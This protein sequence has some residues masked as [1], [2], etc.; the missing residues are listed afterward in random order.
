M[1]Y[2]LQSVCL[3]LFFLTPAAVLIVRFLKPSRMPWWAVV[4][5]IALGGWIFVN[6]YVYFRFEHL[7][8]LVAQHGD[9][10]PED[11]VEDLYA[12]GAQRVMTFLLGGLYSLIYSIPFLVL[13]GVATFI[14]NWLRPPQNGTAAPEQMPAPQPAQAYGAIPAQ[15]YGGN[16]AQTYGANPAQTYGAN[17]AQ[18]YGADP[19]QT[20]GVHPAQ[21]HGAPPHQVGDGR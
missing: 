19:A 3:G 18:T 17:P 16:P 20:Y 8:D 11:L 10:A 5:I 6:G 4:L 13:Y 21:A 2:V 12:D 7:A 15:T 14:R 9:N 1:N